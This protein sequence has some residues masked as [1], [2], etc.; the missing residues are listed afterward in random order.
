MSSQPQIAETIV[1]QLGHSTGRMKAMVGAHSFMAT[2]S[3][4][5]FKMKARAKGSIKVCQ[6][7]LLPSDT[8]RVRFLGRTGIVKAEHTGVYAEDLRPLFERETG[9]YLSL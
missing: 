2:E 1:Q 9:L 3:G 8:Y 6:I 4:L 5:Q 7:E